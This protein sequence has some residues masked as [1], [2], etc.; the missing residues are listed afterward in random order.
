M[1]K[2]FYS[3]IILLLS[4]T[5]FAQAPQSFKYQAVVRDVS[6]EIIAY[7]QV[8]FQISI[9]QNSASGTAVY[10][11]THFDSTNQFGL[12]TLEIGTGTTTDDFIG[13][14]WSN[15]AYFIQIEMDAS[16]GTSYTLMGTSQLLSVPYALHAK[17]ATN[18]FSGNYSDLTNKPLIPDTLKTL[19]TDAG[20]K[21]ITNLPDPTY[22][23][24][25]ATKAYVDA[26]RQHVESLI[27][28]IYSQI[29]IPTNGLIAE[30]LFEDNLN[31]TK[32]TGT[33]YNLNIVQ[34]ETS[35]L[36]GKVGKVCYILISSISNKCF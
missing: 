2:L 7:Q 17:T 12:V 3:I 10:T 26:L 25:A 24:D 5:V 30:W 33:L 20:N 21:N 16:G 13:I 19:V 8:S 11:E 4:T 18:T 34:G 36:S 28:S 6:G 23:Q 1:K 9:L 32:S 22:A 27:D 31:D 29:L 15:D 35:Y 14:D